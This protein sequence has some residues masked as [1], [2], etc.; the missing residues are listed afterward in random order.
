MFAKVFQGGAS[1]I[2]IVSASGKDPSPKLLKISQVTKDYERSIKGYIYNIERASTQTVLQCPA[3]LKDSLG[4]YHQY[5]VLQVYPFAEKQVHLEVVI[6]DTKL[7]RRR[8]LFS[9][10]FQK[11]ESNELH[12]QIPWVMENRGIW[13]NVII[14]LKGLS[15]RC[16][17]GAVFSVLESFTLRPCCHLRK[18]FTVPEI[19]FRATLLFPHN[20]CFPIGIDS[21]VCLL[22]DGIRNVPQTAV[23]SGIGSGGPSGRDASI[24]SETPSVISR[25]RS[26]TTK[27]SA[28]APKL[29]ASAATSNDK[30]SAKHPDVIEA[31]T[32]VVEKFARPTNSDKLKPVLS[33]D[34]DDEVSEGDAAGCDEEE[35]NGR[36]KQPEADKMSL[37]YQVLPGSPPSSTSRSASRPLHPQFNNHE[38]AQPTEIFQVERHAFE[39]SP[40]GA[41]GSGADGDSTLQ[42]MDHRSSSRKVM[43]QVPSESGNSKRASRV[44]QE[45]EHDAG[46]FSIVDTGSNVQNIDRKSSAMEFLQQTA[47]VERRASEHLPCRA[48]E[49]GADGDSNLQIV[50]RRPSP[51][52]M[53]QAPSGS[54][55]S[56]WA[57]RVDQD[58]EHD[59]GVNADGYVQNIDQISSATEFLQRTTQGF[60]SSKRSSGVTR[61]G[62]HGAEQLTVAAAVGSPGDVN[63]KSSI[64][65]I[66]QQVPSESGS[67]DQAGEPDTERLRR[68]VEDTVLDFGGNVGH[69]HSFGEGVNLGGPYNKPRIPQQAR[70]SVEDEVLL[71]DV[72]D[73]GIP[74]AFVTAGSSTDFV[75]DGADILD[76]ADVFDGPAEKGS[77]VREA[78]RLESLDTM[79]SE[80]I[81]AGQPPDM[82]RTT[83]LDASQFLPRSPLRKTSNISDALK[84]SEGRTPLKAVSEISEPRLKGQEGGLA[85]DLDPLQVLKKRR[86]R[87]LVLLRQAVNDYEAEY[88]E[89]VPLF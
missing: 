60:G 17:H 39:H 21:V 78:T 30:N 33:E 4:I 19:D 88:H 1:P 22:N 70:A 37:E 28:P 63:H 14:D 31:E 76:G 51:R 52:I 45:G 73:N 77:T 74:T 46:R 44:G 68:L 48:D 81:I 58:D 27:G 72:V 36:I 43:Q 6:S 79:D 3:N 75:L 47:L 7:Q 83:D 64:R 20:V 23:P 59:V 84:A 57:N 56:K 12:C 66:L 2:E 38:P 26:V 71:E 49:S 13:N 16:F 85:F 69:R 35:F 50:D 62:A 15:S 10:S 8:L 53:Q 5:L 80:N 40:R 82:W 89:V 24:I 65:K 87:L 41:D 18:V 55:S 61:V 34:F 42:I 11:L 29:V 25:Q 54:G 67:F 86:E 32:T 9:T